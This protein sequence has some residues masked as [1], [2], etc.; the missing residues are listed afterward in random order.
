MA[1]SHTGGGVAWMA[2]I[3][4]FV[5]GMV[6]ILPFKASLKPPSPGSLDCEHGNQQYDD[7]DHKKN[8]HR[9]ENTAAKSGI[10]GNRHRGA[11]MRTGLQLT[12]KFFIALSALKRFHT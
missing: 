6:L 3:G 5:A 2:H 4:G 1:M 7:Q 11:A 12:V 9:H 8:P 10:F